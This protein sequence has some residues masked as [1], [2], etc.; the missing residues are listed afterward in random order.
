MQKNKKLSLCH[1]NWSLIHQNR[2]KK[3]FSEV[4]VRECVEMINLR[5]FWNQ[6]WLHTVTNQ[7]YLRQLW[8]AGLFSDITLIVGETS[9]QVHRAILAVRSD[10]FKA[11]FTHTKEST[12]QFKK[13]MHIL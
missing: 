5:S 13:L 12:I 8:P 6:S 1:L 3:H 9:F 4:D 2:L 7:K 10:Y 11:L